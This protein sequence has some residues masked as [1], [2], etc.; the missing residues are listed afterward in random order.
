MNVHYIP[1]HFHPFYEQL[2]FSRGQFP[3]SESYYKSAISLPLFPGLTEEE[4][5]YVVEKLSKAL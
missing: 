4:Q 3:I 1:V 5:D 2:G